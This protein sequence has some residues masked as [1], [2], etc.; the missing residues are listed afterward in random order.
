MPGIQFEDVRLYSGRLEIY[1]RGEWGTV[2]DPTWDIYD[3]NVVCQ[4]LNRGTATA[5]LVG[6][7]SFGPANGPVLISN[8]DC[9]GDEITLLDCVYTVSSVN[10][11]N[12]DVGAECCEYSFLFHKLLQK[13]SFPLVKLGYFKFTNIIHRP[14]KSTTLEADTLF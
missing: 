6:A 3:A 4:M 8:I 7:A 9:T 10:D 5:A 12:T 11:H 2:S 13:R 1:H 14:T